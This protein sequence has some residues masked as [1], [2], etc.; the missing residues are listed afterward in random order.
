MFTKI[1]S[2]KIKPGRP[3]A[4]VFN[5]LV[6]NNTMI[7]SQTKHDNR[8]RTLPDM[9]EEI[10]TYEIHYIKLLLFKQLNYDRLLE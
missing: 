9:R 1:D 8:V 6:I 5:S 10:N 4:I 2:H 3:T 7:V